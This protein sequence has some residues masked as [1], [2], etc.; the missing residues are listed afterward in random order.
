[1]ILYNLALCAGWGYVLFLVVNHLMK[2]GSFEGAY[3][4]VE[5]QLKIW[6]TAAILEVFFNNFIN[7]FD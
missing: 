2:T 1:L 4:V 3:D 6:Q 5:F 7:L